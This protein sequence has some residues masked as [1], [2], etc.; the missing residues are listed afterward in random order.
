M[1]EK[2]RVSLPVVMLIFATACLGGDPL[3]APDAGS[4]AD[5]ASLNHTDAGTQTADHGQTIED[6]AGLDHS[7][8]SDAGTEDHR[9]P[10]AGPEDRYLYVDITC[11]EIYNGSGCE[12]CRLDSCCS[13]TLACFYIPDC[14]GIWDS[15][16]TCLDEGGDSSQCADDFALGPDGP[17]FLQLVNCWDTFCYLDCNE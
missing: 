12:Q 8:A 2:L 16:N 17:A 6:A 7:L 9:I 1:S 3:A 11:E 4:T 10:D 5:A 15:Y 14:P 13:E